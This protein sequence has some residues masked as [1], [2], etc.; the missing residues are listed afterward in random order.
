[1]I[2][3]DI[4]NEMEDFLPGMSSVII[5]DDSLRQMC[6]DRSGDHR[7]DRCSRTAKYQYH[8]PHRPPCVCIPVERPSPPS[9]NAEHRDAEDELC[10]F[11]KL[12]WFVE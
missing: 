10:W 6:P 11:M 7:R 1:M 5:D 12:F 2:L 3:V 8:L 4:L 9:W